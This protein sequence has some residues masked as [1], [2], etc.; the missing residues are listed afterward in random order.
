[1]NGQGR[2]AAASLATQASGGKIVATRFIR[3]MPSACR[4]GA[5]PASLQAV[6]S[7]RIPAGRP[8]QPSTPHRFSAGPVSSLQRS[9]FQLNL[10]CCLNKKYSWSGVG[11][12]G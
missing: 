8:G 2:L 10:F 9:D 11:W 7:A 3:L 4:V 5:E 1:M 6:P 12:S